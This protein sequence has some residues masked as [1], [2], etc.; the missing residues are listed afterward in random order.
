ML[1]LSQ[2]KTEWSNV[3]QV[4]NNLPPLG[5]CQQRHPP[6]SLYFFLSSSVNSSQEMLLLRFMLSSLIVNSRI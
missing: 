5:R 3:C 1:C 4:K 6:K 2:T